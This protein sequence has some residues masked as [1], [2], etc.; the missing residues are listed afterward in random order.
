MNLIVR[1]FIQTIAVLIAAYILPGVEIDSFLTML[2]VAI[3]LGIVNA[4]LKPILILLTLPIT[5]IT[6][7]LFIFVINAFLVLLVSMVVPGFYVDGF[8]WALLFSVV[9]SL[10]ST[11]LGSL[12]K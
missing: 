10:V 6:L 3:V 1:I 5:I 11:F 12:S 2:I 9:V 7:G 8:L 4:F